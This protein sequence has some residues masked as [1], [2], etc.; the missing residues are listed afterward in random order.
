VQIRREAFTGKMKREL[1]IFRIFRMTQ[2][3]LRLF[4]EFWQKILTLS[5]DNIET[6]ASGYVLL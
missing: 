5:Q 2:I 3:P 4:K 6:F 1:Q